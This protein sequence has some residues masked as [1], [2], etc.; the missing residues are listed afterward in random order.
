MQRPSGFR[1]IFRTDDVARALYSEGAG[2]FRIVPAAVAVPVDVE[3]VVRLV[4]WAG[5]TG[6]PLVPRGAG[7]GMPGGNVGP[8][9]VVDLT[10]GFRE[11]PTIHLDRGFA[12]AGAGVTYQELNRAAAPH[13]VHLPPDPSSGA[14]CTL[15]GMA[16]TNAAGA[17]SLRYGAMRPWVTR[18]DFVTADAEVGWVATF[19]A[20]PGAGTAA[21]R[22]YWR[23]VIPGMERDWSAIADQPSRPK[24]SS[25]FYLRRGLPG[26]VLQLLIGS[27]G[28]LA[29]ITAVEVRLAPLPARRETLLASLRSLEDI[30]PAVAALGPLEP[31]A[32][33]V[34]D[35]TYLDFVRTAAGALVPSGTEAVLLVEFEGQARGAE[36]RLGNLPIST[37]HAADDAAERLWKLR[38][39]ASPLLASLPGNLRSLQVVEDAC[40][41]LSLLSGYIE[42]LRASAACHG[43]EVVIFGHAGDGHVHANLLADVRQSDLVKRLSDCLYEMSEIAAM[44]NGTLSG[45]HGDGRLRASLLQMVFKEPY[46]ETCR[47]VKRAFDPAG[48]MNPGVKV[49]PQRPQKLVL[50]PAT[51]KVGPDAPALPAEAAAQLRRIEREAG[52]GTFR[53]DLAPEAAPTHP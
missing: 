15:G 6:H 27:E 29:F 4:Q 8:G 25:G 20:D 3:D 44:C 18:L 50:D 36:D 16:S 39:L 12:R 5:E 7:S 53:L 21:E 19:D 10:Q 41:P 2:I 33:E 46:L 11:A 34:L 52:W 14:F 24:N 42:K 26:R 40:V 32:I 31:S 48:I 9:V 35:R 38:H 13:G 22:R 17:R 28:T 45:E 43:F 1:G 30:A 49:P 47:R 37:I 23:D 51:L